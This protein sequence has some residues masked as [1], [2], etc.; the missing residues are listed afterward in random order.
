MN[1][2]KDGKIKIRTTQSFAR[3]IGIP[4]FGIEEAVEYFKIIP[5]KQHVDALLNIPFFEETLAECKD[6]H[7]LVAVFPL[8]IE[9]IYSRVKKNLFHKDSQVLISII[10]HRF[11][12]DCGEAGWHLVRKTPISN[13]MNRSWRNQ[14]LLVS[15]DEEIPTSR[16]MIYTIIG[17]YLAT[18][19]Y[20]I[21]RRQRLFENVCVRCS[22]EDSTFNRIYV[23]CFSNGLHISAP[24]DESYSDDLGLASERKPD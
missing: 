5:T 24:W 10:K 11:I 17:H 18:G 1:S 19:K 13:S 4:I 22:D 23:G 20:F 9:D 15:E 7:I 21:K 12:K 14:L 2:I 16:V 6:T 3:A 8:S